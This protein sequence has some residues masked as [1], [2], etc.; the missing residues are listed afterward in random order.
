MDTDEFTLLRVSGIIL[1]IVYPYGSVAL[2][3]KKVVIIL[4]SVK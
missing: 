4:E 1:L 3:V 2:I